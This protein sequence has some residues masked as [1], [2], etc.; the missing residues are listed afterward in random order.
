MADKQVLMAAQND[1]QLKEQFERAIQLRDLGD[2]EG[3]RLIFSQLAEN[4][5]ALRRCLAC[6]GLCY[7]N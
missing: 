2:F 6:L 7:V 4:M 5:Q 1:D 3:A